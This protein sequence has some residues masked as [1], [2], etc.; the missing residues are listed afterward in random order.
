MLYKEQIQLFLRI[1]TSQMV[2]N[3]GFLANGL[4]L[5]TGLHILT[6]SQVAN[7]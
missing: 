1:F 6:V 3:E 2:K 4:F 7:F 5:Y